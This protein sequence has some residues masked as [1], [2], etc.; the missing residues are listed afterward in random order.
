MNDA[1]HVVFNGDA[2]CYIKKEKKNCFIDFGFGWE[3]IKSWKLI[4][5]Y[6]LFGW[7]INIYGSTHKMIKVKK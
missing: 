5:V 1:T 6:W 4:S 2:Y 3:D 7:K